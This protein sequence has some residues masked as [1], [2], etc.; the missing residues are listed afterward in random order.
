MEQDVLFT[1][2]VC[3]AVIAHMNDDH[4]D[5]S[6]RICQGLGGKPEA[7][8]ATLTGLG[9]DGL[10]FEA[11][12]GSTTEMVHIAWTAP[13]VARADI[14]REVVALHEL[15]CAALGISVPTSGEH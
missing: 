8:S 11:T 12:S 1:P 6:L 7:E 2:E 5:D 14:R 4:T 10:V 3:A 15:A 13:V 9:P